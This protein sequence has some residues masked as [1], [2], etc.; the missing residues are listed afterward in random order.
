MEKFIQT[1]FD[2]GKLL[3]KDRVHK[4]KESVDF[5]HVE[6]WLTRVP[7]EIARE[8]FQCGIRFIFDFLA[9]STELELASFAILRGFQSRDWITAL[10]E[11][12]RLGKRIEGSPWHEVTPFCVALMPC[13]LNRKVSPH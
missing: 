11:S 3:C 9:I 4:L 1:L 13:Q 2:L 8:I 5:D 6:G 10:A 7:V 12:I